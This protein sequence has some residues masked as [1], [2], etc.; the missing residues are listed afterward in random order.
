MQFVVWKANSKCTYSFLF[1]DNKSNLNSS[2][3]EQGIFKDNYDTTQT[4][5][6]MPKGYVY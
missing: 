5:V 1:K 4:K 2:C 6:L 3:H